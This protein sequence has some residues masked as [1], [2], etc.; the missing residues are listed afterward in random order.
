MAD[1]RD[2]TILHQ[3]DVEEVIEENVTENFETNLGAVSDDAA[4]ADL[5][6]PSAAYVEAEQVAQQVAI[7]KILSV[8]REANLIPT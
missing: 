4:I 8:L 5:P 6:A 1:A 7:N 3:A 2:E